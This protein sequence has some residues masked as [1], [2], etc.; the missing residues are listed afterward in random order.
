MIEPEIAFADLDELMDLAEDFIREIAS[1]VREACPE[2]M[3]FFN[4]PVYRLRMGHEMAAIALRRCI[5]VSIEVNHS[6]IFFTINIRNSGNV[7]V[8]QRMVSSDHDRYRASFSY[9]PDKLTDWRH[10]ALYAETINRSIAVIHGPQD[11]LPSHPHVHMRQIAP[12]QKTKTG[13]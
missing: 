9:F 8:F 10:A 4:Q 3:A 2:D 1:D 7:G 5:I 11:L 13:T 6:N 12:S